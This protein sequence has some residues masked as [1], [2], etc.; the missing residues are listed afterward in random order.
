MNK[1]TN[2]LVNFHHIA[3]A[4]GKGF[5]LQDICIQNTAGPAKDQAVALRVGADMSVINRCRIDAYQDT[6]Y[7]HSQR[8][9]YRDSYV[10]GTCEVDY[11]KCAILSIELG[12]KKFKS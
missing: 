9:F 12:I 10:T 7:A 8:Q 1:C 6:L 4:V 11:L 3:A 2:I 5:I